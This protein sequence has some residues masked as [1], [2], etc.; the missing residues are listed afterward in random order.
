M[1]TVGHLYGL[2]SGLRHC[3]G[4]NARTISADDLDT[5]MVFKPLLYRTAFPIWKDVNGLA[6]FQVQQHRAVTRASAKGKVVQTQY[7]RRFR[8]QALAAHLLK[9]LEQ[10]CRTEQQTE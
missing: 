4:K 9:A 2:R 10:P 8:S 5:R 3:L 6:R 7:A 1:E